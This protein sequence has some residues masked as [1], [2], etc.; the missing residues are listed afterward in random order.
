MFHPGL[1]FSIAN[2]TVVNINTRFDL[3]LMQVYDVHKPP[4]VLKTADRPPVRGETVTNLAAPHG[5]FWSGTVL[6][7]KGIFS[8]YHTQG[9]SV[10]TIPTKPG[11]SGSPIINSENKLVGVIFAGYR[12]I[13]NVGLSSPLMAIKIFLKK[14]IAKGEMS[15]WDKNNKPTVDTQIDKVWIQKMKSKLEE[16]FGK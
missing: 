13:E 5:L 7:F 1:M 6:I 14:S 10:Y 16:V 15:I 8:G 3:C 12:T 2:A 11:S 4:M 9:Y